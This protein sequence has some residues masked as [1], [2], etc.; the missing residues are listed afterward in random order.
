MSPVHRAAPRATSPAKPF[1][2]IA[3][4]LQR[5]ATLLRFATSTT[6]AADWRKWTEVHTPRKT[7]PG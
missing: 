1:S 4:V 3:T 6:T 7:Q 5:A 2:S